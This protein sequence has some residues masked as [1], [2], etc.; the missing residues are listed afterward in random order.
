MGELTSECSIPVQG[1]SV[2]QVV[3]RVRRD[4]SI[5]GKYGLTKNSQL[6]KQNLLMGEYMV[7]LIY[8]TS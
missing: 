2:A 6:K 4:A 8:I 5:S 1:F 7:L 3:E